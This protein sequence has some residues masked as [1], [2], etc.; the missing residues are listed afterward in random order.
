LACGFITSC[1]LVAQPDLKI[2]LLMQEEEED[3]GKEGE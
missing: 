1:G 3:E 2:G